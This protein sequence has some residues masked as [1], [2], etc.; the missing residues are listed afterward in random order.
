MNR[1]ALS[2]LLGGVLLP[3][4][5]AG[6]PAGPTV[7]AVPGQGKSPAQFQ[8]EE[9]NC[10]ERAAEQAGTGQGLGTA[11]G[12]AAGALL[13][14]AAGVSGPQSRYDMAYTQCLASTG[15]RVQTAAGYGTPA[16]GQGAEQLN[17][18]PYTASSTAPV[19]APYGTGYAPPHTGFYRPGIRPGILGPG[20][21]LGFGFGNFFVY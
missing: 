18:P 9:E 20:L 1:S 2:A 12:A 11:L 13:G 17:A 19:T 3:G 10:R 5:A 16:T 8:R 14:P 15:N 7:I 21:S 4:C 6:P